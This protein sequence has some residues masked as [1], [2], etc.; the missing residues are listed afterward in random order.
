MHVRDCPSNDATQEWTAFIVK[1]VDSID[2][3]EAND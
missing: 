3:D 1:S 2:D